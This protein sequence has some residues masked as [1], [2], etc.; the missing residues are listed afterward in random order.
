MEVLGYLTQ[1]SLI[2]YPFKDRVRVTE[3][4]NPHP[5]EDDWFYDILFTSFLPALRSVYISR[6]EKTEAGALIISFANAETLDSVLTLTAQA[7][8]LICHYGNTIKSFASA[9]NAL[10]TV[11]VVLGPGLVNKPAFLQTYSK[12]E[13]EL[14]SAAITLA[15]PRVNHLEFQAYDSALARE[16]EEPDI[17]F[18][19]KNYATGDVPEPLVQPRYNSEFAYEGGNSGGLLAGRRL[20]AGLYN[21]CNDG[22]ATD[23]YS[24]NNITPDSSGRLFF[25]PS[26]CYTANVLTANDE[27]LL[28]NYLD[29]Y[30][31]ATIHTSPTTTST[32]DV[33][34]LNS[35]IV[36]QN[37]CKPK[38]APEYMNAFAY[39]LN[40][41]TDGASDLGKL[42]FNNS[43]TRGRGLPAGL[44]F[45]ASEFCGADPTFIRCVNPT[46]G[47]SYVDCNA[48]FIK[49]FH[50]GGTLRIAY[51]DPGINQYY[52][53][54]AVSDDG[55]SVTLGSAP[56]ASSDALPFLVDDNGVLSNMNCATRGYNADSAQYGQPYCKLSY[57][58]TDGKLPNNTYGTLLSMAVG[59]FNPSTATKQ[60]Q[61]IYTIANLQSTG[62]IKL[63]KKTGFFTLTE[64]DPVITLQCR[65]YAV[66]DR[67]FSIACNH[68]GGTIAV[69]LWDVTNSPPTQIGA[70]R[71]LPVIDGSVCPDQS[72]NISTTL[73][74]TQTAWSSFAGVVTL[75][76]KSSA[77]TQPLSGGV[78]SWLTSTVDYSEPNPRVLLRAVSAP[79]ETLSTTYSM[80]FN[81][82]TQYGSY[83]TGVINLQYT[84]LPVVNIPSVAY[85]FTEFVFSTN[86]PVY[87]VASRNM[88]VSTSFGSPSAYFYSYTSTY[89][90]GALPEG[91]AFDS[92]T[93]YITGHAVSSFDPFN[94]LLTAHNPAGIS[95]PESITLSAYFGAP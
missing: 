86:H 43:E 87:S 4:V 62:S 16:L 31:S 17:P 84:A 50:E 56:P 49:N 46:T 72:L 22:N 68:S 10:F 83:A 53:I 27:I 7:A 12:N 73:N 3:V 75:D 71:H 15:C 44:V 21:P 38:C 23:L 80:R 77:V 26:S 61:V 14:T 65:E 51:N 85:V 94:L 19:V 92:L 91:L 64:S 60:L 20:G 30:R 37:Y 47:K 48:K 67:V 88:T 1:N 32:V 41:V 35:S 70:T 81:Y 9:S 13:S 25:N 57:T 63:R 76:E 90:G 82:T 24:I 36:L 59:L 52:K 28:G 69:D 78:P 74:I 66:L 29:P 34:S 89:P 2:S 5:I 58:A 6:L 18:V 95:N 40:R 79:E 45:T 55:Q 8:E 11:K 39:Y 42:A 33:V 54:V 93:G